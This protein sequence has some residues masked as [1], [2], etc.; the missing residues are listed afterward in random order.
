[1]VHGSL[2]HSCLTN[3][4]HDS[5]KGGARFYPSNNG[6]PEYKSP[7]STGIPRA[8]SIHHF[9]TLLLNSPSTLTFRA[10]RT[11]T[12]VWV[13]QRTSWGG[14]GQ[15]PWAVKWLDAGCGVFPQHTNPLCPD[16]SSQ[17]QEKRAG[18]FTIRPPGMQWHVPVL[19]VQHFWMWCATVKMVLKVHKNK[20]YMPIS[21]ISLWIRK[22]PP[23]FF[24]PQPLSQIYLPF[25]NKYLQRSNLWAR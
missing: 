7:K 22:V 14:S 25:F 16:Y 23:G 12:L 1:M 20:P 11:A 15:S 24:R 5:K 19:F 13:T 21:L 6:Q 18:N 8:G 4:D 3:T 9:L 2:K 10:R 17:T